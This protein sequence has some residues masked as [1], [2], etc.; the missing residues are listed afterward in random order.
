MSQPA[1]T[2]GS[3]RRARATMR[4]VAERAG[5]GIKTVSR[6]VNGEPGVAAA[7]AERVNRA[8]RELHFQPDPFAGNLRRSVRRTQS[9]GLLL[10]SV[11]NPYCAAVHRAVED[12][13]ESR[14]VSVLSAS[15]DEDPQRER[16]LVGTFVSRRVDGLILSAT[17]GDQAYLRPE[18]DAGTP[19]VAVDRAPVGID[20]DSVVVDNVAGA[21][22]ATAHLLRRG[23][24]RI[25]HLGDLSM[26]ATAT[27]RLDGFRQ[28]AAEAGV[29]ADDQ[30]VVQD[31]HTVELAFDATFRL[32]RSDDPPTALFTSQNLVTIGA[33]R[34]LRSL[35]MQHDVAVVGFDDFA[36][37]DLL[38]PAVTVVAQDPVAIGRAAAERVFARLEDRSL[39]STQTVL[40]TRLVVRGSG[41]IAP[42][43]R[44]SA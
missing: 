19:V 17:G 24:R 15:S 16:A 33:I 38:D 29:P 28:A 36:L 26:I 9:I 39:P 34:A 43:R 23:H 37:A 42:R 21:R 1:D 8:A 3:P 7:T 14:G 18:M 22:G 35:G 30:L 20:V 4:D 2:N 13:A 44:G 32:L 41:E 11:D 10:S 12:V 27:Q 6:V 5:V 40:A 25:A 31:L